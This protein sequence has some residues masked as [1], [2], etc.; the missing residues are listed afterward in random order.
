ML[1][2][3]V[4][5]ADAVGGDAMRKIP[6]IRSHYLSAEPT[7]ETSLP[8]RDA[9]QRWLAAQPWTQV[10]SPL[11]IRQMLEWT[12]L[13]LR[14]DTGLDGELLASWRQRFRDVLDGQAWETAF[15]LPWTYPVRSRRLMPGSA[16]IVGDPDAEC[17]AR[18][19]YPD[20]VI[21]PSGLVLAPPADCVA[22]ALTY[23]CALPG[24]APALPAWLSGGLLVRLE[25]V[26]AGRDW[27]AAFP[28]PGRV[29]APRGGLRALVPTLLLGLEREALQQGTRHSPALPPAEALA[30]LVTYRSISPD[31]IAAAFTCVRRLATG[32][33]LAGA[34]RPSDWWPCLRA[35]LYPIARVTAVAI[36]RGATQGLSHP[37]RRQRMLAGQ[38]RRAWRDLGA[39][40]AGPQQLPGDPS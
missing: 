32:H 9:L 25:C 22:Q 4:D 15:P 38:P 33:D 1:A 11:A 2:A 23:F 35:T 24:E 14:R 29:T 20:R 19:Q 21:F 37:R 26:L 36:A 28:L 7:L 3:R 8:Q 18:F 27:E 5:T 10:R 34:P 31:T 40:P 17:R 39:A 30:R 16:A 6:W 13:L 12:R